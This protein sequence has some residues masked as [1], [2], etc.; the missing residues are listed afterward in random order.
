L[1]G[2][3]DNAEMGIAGQDTLRTVARAAVDDEMLD[4]DAR[5]CAHAFHHLGDEGGALRQGG[6]EAD[7]RGSAG[8]CRMFV[9]TDALDRPMVWI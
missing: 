7:R 5:L 9:A 2:P 3:A 6:D 1:V 8:H 4:S